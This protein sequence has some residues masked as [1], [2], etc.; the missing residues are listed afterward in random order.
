MAVSHS[1][2]TV[3]IMKIKLKNNQFV[4]PVSGVAHMEH[5]KTIVCGWD[6]SCRDPQAKFFL[7]KTIRRE[8]YILARASEQK[9]GGGNAV[10]QLDMEHKKYLA[11]AVKRLGPF[12]GSWTVHIIASIL[13]VLTCFVQAAILVLLCILKFEYYKACVDLRDD[14]KDYDTLHHSIMCPSGPT[15]TD[16][17]KWILEVP[18]LFVSVTTLLLTRFIVMVGDYETWNSPE[19]KIYASMIRAG[20]FYFTNLGVFYS[21]WISQKRKLKG[22]G[23]S[24]ETIFGKELYRLV[25]IQGLT[26]VVLNIGVKGVHYLCNRRKRG[27]KRTEFRTE[28][29]SLNMFFM[30]SISRIGTLFCPPLS[31]FVTM[32]LLLDF[33]Q[34]RFAL[35]YLSSQESYSAHASHVYAPFLL[36]FFILCYLITSFMNVYYISE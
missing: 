34:N 9:E 8:M 4:L 14:D 20:L 19:R 18:A 24:A 22:A 26:E 15:G 36:T 2:H 13:I 35:F 29:S 11:M 17:L 12:W 33:Y 25:V 30:H 3:M 1:H 31:F 32:R 23:F 6:S 16:S 21:F 5:F 10:V 28:Y 7:H 27:F